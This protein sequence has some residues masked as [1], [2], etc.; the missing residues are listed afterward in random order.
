MA[1]IGLGRDEMDYRTGHVPSCLFGD[2]DDS[3]VA[4]LSPYRLGAPGHT[5]VRTRPKP[6]TRPGVGPQCY[7]L[8]ECLD[9]RKFVDHAPLELLGCERRLENFPYPIAR[10]NPKRSK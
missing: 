1:T 6:S 8:H 9:L 2:K 4:D 10:A 3:V 5:R 7:F